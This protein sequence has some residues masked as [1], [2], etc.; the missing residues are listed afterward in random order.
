MIDHLKPSADAQEE[1]A[2][3]REDL[4]AFYRPA[5]SEERLAV[6][7]VALARQSMFRAARAEAS[8][9]NVPAGTELHT[10]LGTE[11]FK[12]FLRYQ[13]QAE[14]LYRVAVEELMLLLVRRR[15]ALA[16]SQPAARAVKPQLVAAAAAP[17]T[18]PPAA[19][20]SS[21]PAAANTVGNLA[22]RL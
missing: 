22:L 14:R 13:A 18:P 3:L 10:V 8:L 20:P 9:F 21:G 11:A 17:C 12:V 5:N 4:L 7:R 2:R 15:P 1:L 16:P 6:E 19:A